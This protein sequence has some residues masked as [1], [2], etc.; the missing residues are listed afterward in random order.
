M[1]LS[2]RAVLSFCHDLHPAS[3]REG[4]EF[5]ASHRVDAL[6]LDG[7]EAIRQDLMPYIEDGLVV[8]L[9]DNDIPGLTV[10]RVFAGNRKAS[11]RIVGH[12]LDLGHERVATIH[13]NLRDS[14]GRERLAGFHDAFAAH[15]RE[16]DPTL[17]VDGQWKEERAYEGIRHLLS[18]PSPP[19]ALFSANY[20]MTLGVLTYLHESGLRLPRDLSLVSYDDVPAFRLHNPAITTVEQPIEKMADT[21]T[22]IIDARLSNTTAM[23]RHDIRIDCSIILRDS[24]RRLE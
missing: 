21:I 19:T 3:I 5:F 20:N 24:A 22:G 6:V 10:D 16:P 11:A 18:L 13:G 14:A 23:G 12:L 1:R 17:I 7:E 15:D 2:G 4:L 9:Y 8:V